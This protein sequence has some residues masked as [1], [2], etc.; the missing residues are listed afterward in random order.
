MLDPKW[1]E[2]FKLP[3]RAAISLSL[4]S[5]ALLALV[6]LKLLDLGLIGVIALPILIIVAIVSTI[7]TVVRIAELFFYPLYEKRRFSA[8]EI[9]RAVRRKEQDEHRSNTEKAVLSQLD[10]LSKEEIGVVI[11]ALNRGSP[12]FFTYVHSPAVGILL[13]KSLVWSPGGH[14]NQDHYPFSFH[15]FVWK[16]LLERK[17]EFFTKD[18]EHREEERRGINSRRG[19]Y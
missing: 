9:R 2:L 17:E 6:Y 8:L 14:H 5:A 10:Y 1:L 13:G 3:M 12:T 18:A 7:M 4:A 19:S 11:T 16:V 15:D